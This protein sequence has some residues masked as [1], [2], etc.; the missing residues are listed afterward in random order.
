MYLFT[1]WAKWDLFAALSSCR[2]LDP[3]IKSVGQRMLGAE[4]HIVLN[5]IHWQFD[6]EAVR[7]TTFYNSIGIEMIF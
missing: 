2:F 7:F 6:R 1:V 3:Y 5:Y 4:L